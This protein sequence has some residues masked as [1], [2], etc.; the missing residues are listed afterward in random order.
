MAKSR[1]GQRKHWAEEAR[2]WAW[3]A[4]IKRRCSWSDYRLDHEFAWT[5]KGRKSNSDTTSHRPRT[6]EWIRKVARKPK[7]LDPRWRSM[8]ELV[9]A[10]EKHPQFGG[11]QPLYE[12]EIWDMFQETAPTPEAV[13]ERIDRLLS[14]N[15]LVRTP[16]EKAFEKGRAPISEFALQSVFDRCLLIS[17]R[18]MDRFSRIALVWSLYVQTEPA[19]N[20]LIRAVVEKI[21]DH[22]LEHFFEYL[23]PD[24]YLEYYDNAIGALLQTRL[25]LSSRRISGYGYIEILGTWPVVPEDLV[26]K[27]TP[28]Y[29][30]AETNAL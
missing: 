8:D 26:G 11:T 20:Q 30:K 21:A 25:D 2:V 27:L 28:E 7:G 5:E 13:Q 15:R 18:Q 29:L 10:I 4:E 12:A 19:H 16:I 14:A 3:Y 17:L 23:L 1:G 9:I 6:F 22:Q 24:R